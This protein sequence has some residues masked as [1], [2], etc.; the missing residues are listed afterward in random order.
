MSVNPI[1]KKAIGKKPR[2]KPA[3][4]ASGTATR[5]SKRIRRDRGAIIWALGFFR[6]FAARWRRFPC[7]QFQ[8]PGA[9]L[10][11]VPGLVELRSAHRLVS[12]IPG[13]S[14]RHGRGWLEGAL[15][16]P[17]GQLPPGRCHVSWSRERYPPN[18]LTIRVSPGPDLM[19]HAGAEYSFQ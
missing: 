10:H 12:R 4:V 6:G 1:S 3:T 2:F 8:I 7:P 14:M 17:E 9:T 18:K 16:L 5:D 15:G 11:G 19:Q 13:R